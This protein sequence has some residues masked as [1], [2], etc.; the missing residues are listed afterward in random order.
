MYALT[1][2]KSAS[3]LSMPHIIF[4]TIG[5]EVG[6][7]VLAKMKST[8]LQNPPRLIDLPFFKKSQNNINYCYRTLERALI[9]INSQETSRKIPQN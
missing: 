4:S 3:Y 9:L 2:I 5:V 1:V 6:P 8:F 7:F